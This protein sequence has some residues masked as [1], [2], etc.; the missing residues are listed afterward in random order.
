MSHRK[1]DPAYQAWKTARRAE[2]RRAA[3]ARAAELQRR[4]PEYRA[5]ITDDPRTAVYRGMVARALLAAGD[6][7]GAEAE[8]RAAIGQNPDFGPF[9]RDLAQLLWRRRDIAGA[10]HALRRW[11]E[12]EPTDPRPLASLGRALDAASRRAEARAAWNDAIERD[13]TC[14]IAAEVR[15][16][17]LQHPPLEPAA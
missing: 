17:L 15:K 11:S 6:L 9:Y 16:L 7:D 4:I 8:L 14:V 1:R 3:Q 13:R 2:R 5:G 12:A 10:I